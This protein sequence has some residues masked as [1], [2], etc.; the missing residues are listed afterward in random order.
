MGA[1]AHEANGLE[2]TV[3]T[4][5]LEAQLFSSSAILF[6]ISILKTRVL[7]SFPTS[8]LTTYCGRVQLP[9]LRALWLLKP[10]GGFA[11]NRCCSETVREKYIRP[12]I[13]GER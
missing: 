9:P 11:I 2:E 5:K 6:I 12:A 3:I 13:R 7:S 8:I 10:D 4:N 1:I